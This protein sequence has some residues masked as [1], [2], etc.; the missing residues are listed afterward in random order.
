MVLGFE[1]P[2]AKLV[3]AIFVKFIRLLEYTGK[4]IIEK[5]FFLTKFYFM[6]YFSSY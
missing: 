1:M 2:Q 4:L 5:L 6:D 3:R